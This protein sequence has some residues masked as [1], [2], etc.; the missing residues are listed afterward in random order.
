MNYVQTEYN[1]LT[2]FIE[3][4]LK[5]GQIATT[6]QAWKLCR[7]LAGYSTIATL[8]RTIIKR[9]IDEGRAEKVKHGQYRIL[10]NKGNYIF[11]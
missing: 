3:A 8:F 4:N 6:D 11:G 2:E 10:K 1:T 7:H 5:P 9:L